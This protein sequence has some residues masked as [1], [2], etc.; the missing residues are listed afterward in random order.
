M[1]VLIDSVNFQSRDVAHL[2]ID[3]LSE[4]SVNKKSIPIIIACNKQG[5][6][7]IIIIIIILFILFLFQRFSF[8]IKC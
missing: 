6:W 3:L 4:P 8:G 2:L 1:V 7:G 5:R